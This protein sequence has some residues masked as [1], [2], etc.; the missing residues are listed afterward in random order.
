MARF[1]DYRR[2]LKLRSRSLRRDS[3]PAER[4]L[5]L[6]FL[7]EQPEKFTR[8]KPLAGYIADFYCSA[9]RLIIEV[10]GDSHFT[11]S[12]IDDARTATLAALGIRIIRFTN[13]DVGRQIGTYRASHQ[14]SPSKGECSMKLG[15]TIVFAISL[16][17]LPLGAAF[18]GEDSSQRFHSTGPEWHEV[19]SAL[20][21]QDAYSDPSDVSMPAGSSVYM[22]ERYDYPA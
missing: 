8:Q 22:L 19:T 16:S 6:E 21:Y 14:H 15:R 7:R 12:G 3:T 10:D 13:E 17:A 9:H 11:G 1:I 2:A 20:Q 4:K 5:W 18:A